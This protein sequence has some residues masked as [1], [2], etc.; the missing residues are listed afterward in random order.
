MTKKLSDKEGGNKRYNAVILTLKDAFTH[1]FKETV[2]GFLSRTVL[3]MTCV[4]YS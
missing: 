3:T 1:I 4:Q 2:P